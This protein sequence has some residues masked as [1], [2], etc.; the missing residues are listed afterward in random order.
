MRKASVSAQLTGFARK[1]SAAIAPQLTKLDPVASLVRR[2]KLSIRIGSMSQ[3]QTALKQFVLHNSA[4]FDPVEF[5]IYDEQI[6]QVVMT[7]QFFAEE[8][9]VFEGTRR[10]LSVVLAESDPDA[11]HFTLAKIRHPISGIKVYEIVSVPNRSH[12]YYITNCMDESAKCQFQVHSNFWRK[13]LSTCGFTFVS[14]YFTV[15]QDGVPVGFVT[16]GGTIVGENEIKVEWCDEADME[17]R[18]LILCIGIVQTVREAFPSLLHI[19]QEYRIKQN[20]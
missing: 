13:L 10:V 20:S 17:L 5:E 14:D 16:P 11:D 7:A 18:I 15:D 19:L 6:D 12:Q 3:L 4:N 9:I 1:F 8:V 2:R